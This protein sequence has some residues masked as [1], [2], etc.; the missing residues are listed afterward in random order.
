MKKILTA[1]IL[2]GTAI[3]VHAQKS[4]DVN[5]IFKMLLF[6][7]KPN[8]HYEK[9]GPLNAI[10]DDS[11]YLRFK[12]IVELTPEKL[13]AS[14]E[15]ES[16][17]EDEYTFY[18]VDLAIASSKHYKMQLEYREEQILGLFH[19]T[20]TTYIIAI[21]DTRGKCYRITG[22]DQSDF[23][24]FLMDFKE[25][26]DNKTSKS[27][28]TNK[29]LKNFIVEGVD[30]SCLYDGLRENKRDTK[31]YPCLKRVNDPVGAR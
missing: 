10:K 1:I 3:C 15:L 9:E 19:G 25:L 8:V 23:L 16:F 7:N 30:F 5:S 26:Y 22:F 13:P 31:K 6:L 27:L 4:T 11:L 20:Y 14:W 18:K 2:M 17:M 29:F 12:D 24:A 21:D 28:S